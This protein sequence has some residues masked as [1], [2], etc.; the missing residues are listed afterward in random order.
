MKTKKALLL[1][2]FSSAFISISFSQNANQNKNYSD[3]I[4]VMRDTIPQMMKEKDVPGLSI[5]IVDDKGI[6]WEEGFGFT[7]KDQ[8][9]TVTPLTNFSIQSMSKNFTAL[10]VLMA[11]Q[12]GLL[13]LDKPITDYI[14]GFTVNSRFEE[15]PERK[16]TLRLLL[17]HRAGFTHEAPIG[18][19]YDFYDQKFDD[20]IKSISDT[21]LRF[22][23]GERYSYSNLGIDLAGFI[24]Q[25]VSGMP[26]HQYVKEKIFNPIG[27]TESSFDIETIK[28][29]GNRAI[30]HTSSPIKP[31]VEV[32]M[33]AAGG[34][35]SNV[36]DLSLYI[37]FQLNNGAVNENQIIKREMLN[38]MLSVPN[39]KK[40]QTTGYALG[41]SV[42]RH[43]KVNLFS[44]GGGG[45]GFLTNMSWCPEL[46]VGV[47]ALTNSNGHNLNVIIPEMIGNML[48]EMKYGNVEQ[49]KPDLSKICKDTIQVDTSSQRKFVGQ[50]L[51]NRAGYMLLE[52]QDGK[53]GIT[54]G[55]N[56][57]PANFV[58]EDELFFIISGFPH[59]YKFILDENKIPVTMIRE[60][61][62]EFL[63]LNDRPGEPPGTFKPEWEKYTG[64]YALIIYGF[65]A[66]TREVIKKNGYLYLDNMKL[67]EHLPGLF[68]T[69]HGET[70]DL[71]TENPTWKNVKIRKLPEEDKK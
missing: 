13:E 43:G 62:G 37:K 16:M 33:L 50:Y 28:K 69:V 34:M 3:I 57:R 40:N 49:P 23:V 21:W 15:H 36:H 7:S 59:Y 48:L 30:G 64:K 27:M 2:L 47:V 44:H 54:P 41:T 55:E 32:P 67:T 60:Y 70:L 61:D 24:L 11:V 56:F 71:R 12:D 66:E 25:Q 26:F 4:R 18:N 38:E 17:S 51:F 8:K 68:F 6:I 5:A 39:R 9:N 1:F 31:P 42:I 22:R 52:W 46:N 19:N 29:M 65:P 53:L 63:D 45:Y 20:H 35:Y 58:S 10:A 14:P